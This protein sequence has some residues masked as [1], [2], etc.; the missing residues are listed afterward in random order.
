MAKYRKPG[1]GPSTPVNPAEQE[2]VFV[3]KTLEVTN[4]AQRNRPILT[5]A[6]V[7]LGLGTAAFVYYGRYRDTLNV[8]AASQLEELQQRLEMGDAEAVREDL[9][10]YLERFGSTSFA[11]EARL[12]LG[13]ILATEGDHAGA[14]TVLEPLAG[15][16]DDPLGAQAAVLLAAVSE[17]MGDVQVAEGLYERLADRAHLNFQRT[18]ALIDVARLRRDRG[19]HAGALAAYD[20][21]LDDMDETDP[22]RARIEMW[23][24]EAAERAR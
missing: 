21:L 13:Q 24:A 9:N 2:D 3:A 19:D 7:V 14:A 1:S 20:R 10:L 22:D 16:V 23:R 17:D 11:D 18:E 6:V 4:W 15:D 12:T 8:T 5:L